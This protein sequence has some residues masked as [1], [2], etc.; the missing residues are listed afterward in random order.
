M[1]GTADERS[2]VYTTGS[3]ENGIPQ[4]IVLINFDPAI[5]LL[6]LE[7]Y[8]SDSFGDTVR[9]RWISRE[10]LMYIDIGLGVYLGC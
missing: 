6:G 1:T 8:K 9:V 5:K 10:Q 2:I 7:R 3:Y 4:A